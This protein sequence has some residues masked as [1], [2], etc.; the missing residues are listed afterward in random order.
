[1]G[2]VRGIYRLISI[3]VE[4]DASERADRDCY[5]LGLTLYEASLGA[6]RGDSSIAV[7]RPAPDP[8]ELTGLT[9]LTP[10]RGHCTQ[11]HRAKRADRFASAA[12]FQRP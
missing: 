4:P 3:V 8:R 7:G 2:A 11:G 5:A 1:M 6:T 10:T 9:D 12:E